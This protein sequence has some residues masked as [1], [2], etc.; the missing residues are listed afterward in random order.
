MSS[1]VKKKN[2]RSQPTRS[3]RGISQSANRKM[4]TAHARKR[5]IRS[6]MRGLLALTT[7][8]V[9]AGGVFYGVSHWQEGIKKVNTV[10]PPQP[11][12][13]IVFETD[14][15]LSKSWVE[16][17]LAL[18]ENIDIMSIDIHQKKL[19]LEQHG[20]VKSTVIRRLPDQL[21]IGI[22]ERTPVVRLAT[23]NEQGEVVGLLVDREGH[24]Y[25][26]N[27][28]DRHELA[29][30]PFLGGV[31][32]QREG[33]GFRRIPGIDQVDDLLRVARSQWPHLYDSWKVVDCGEPPLLKVRS[34][35][36]REIVFS[37]GRYT[38][39]L[40][41]LDMIIENNR[42]QLLGRQERVD[43]SLGNQ[44]VVR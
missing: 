9:V 32:L 43:L 36:I 38:E 17:L 21:V 10:L 23:R 6:A 35:E 31:G 16:E 44:V 27:G 22:K 41:W 25:A 18:P 39:Q 29:T 34:D 13:E 33:D 42:R 15:V 4:V 37:P 1:K 28:Y 5:I 20:Q 3:W 19:L 40:K 8:A 2:V 12:R 11:L 7:V 24:V 30:L 14:G 26:G